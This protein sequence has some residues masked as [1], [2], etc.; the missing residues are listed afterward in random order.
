MWW[1]GYRQEN[2]GIVVQIS[3]GQ[4]VCLF[5]RAS[6]LAVQA[7][8]PPIQCRPRALSAV[9]KAASEYSVEIRGKNVP[10]LL[11]ERTDLSYDQHLTYCGAICCLLALLQMLAHTEKYNVEQKGTD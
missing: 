7:T 10:T 5:S 9:G 4:Q 11:A 3:G 8:Y 6:R 2:Q 1:L